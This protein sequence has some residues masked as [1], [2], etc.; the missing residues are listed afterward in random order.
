MKRYLLFFFKNYFFWVLFFVV[1]KAIFLIANHNFT[2]ALSAGEVLKVF[3][4]G[5]KMDLSAAGYLSLVPGVVMALMPFFPRVAQRVV[6]GYTLVVIVAMTI[7][8][9][10]DLSLYPAWGTRLDS[11]VIPYL[12]DPVAVVSSVSNMQLV[13]SFLAIALIVF[14]SYLA[15]SR[16]VANG[17]FESSVKWYVATPSLLLLTALLILPIRGGVDTSPL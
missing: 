15:Y 14:L 11:Q 12:A 2:S 9:L 8:G 4:Y 16:L 1:F 7:M 13:L 10:A 3:L 6:K 17:E 5:L